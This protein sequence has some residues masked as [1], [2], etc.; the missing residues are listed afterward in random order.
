MIH[1]APDDPSP[2]RRHLI[3]IAGRATKRSW[4]PRRR[5]SDSSVKMDRCSRWSR[6]KASGVAVL[7]K[8]AYLRAPPRSQPTA[9]PDRG[10][11]EP[12]R[13]STEPDPRS[14]CNG[15]N[16]RLRRGRWWKDR[17]RRM[18]MRPGVLTACWA[19]GLQE[20]LGEARA[21]LV[22]HAGL[23]PK[24]RLEDFDTLLEEFDQRRIRIALYGEV[25]AGKST[26]INALAGSELSP[27]AF[28][29]LTSLPV[30]LTYGPETVWRVGSGLSSAS[31]RLLV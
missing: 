17:M 5:P 22:D 14:S 21:A 12:I 16:R 28:D 26:L 9:V 3:A 6:V 30:R 4:R 18:M 19:T 25:K 23:L 1:K 15:V 7:N 10:R 2:G 8:L 13:R 31:K 11:R 27:S 20:A 29:P 24:G